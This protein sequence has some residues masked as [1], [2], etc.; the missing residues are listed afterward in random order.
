MRCL[1]PLE[2]QPGGGAAYSFVRSLRECIYGV[3]RHAV[4]LTYRD[5]FYR[6]R[7]DKQVR[8]QQSEVEKGGI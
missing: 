4:T 6:Y 5:G 8:R 2:P 1:V 7:V 3:V